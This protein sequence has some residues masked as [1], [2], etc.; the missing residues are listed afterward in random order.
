MPLITL[1]QM[2]T[3]SMTVITLPSLSLIM[4]TLDAQVDLRDDEVLSLL[5]TRAPLR[6]EKRTSVLALLQSEKTIKPLRRDSNIKLLHSDK[7]TNLLH[8]DKN[9]NRLLSDKITD[10]LRND[11]NINPLQR[12][13]NIDLCISSSRRNHRHH[14]HP[15]RR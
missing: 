10:L 3:T 7:N 15:L 1:N 4:N 11:S 8:S 5:A 13:K 6:H 12:N 9:T 14:R 2:P